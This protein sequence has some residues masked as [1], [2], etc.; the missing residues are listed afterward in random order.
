[1]IEN[2]HHSP[3]RSLTR[4]DLRRKQFLFKTRNTTIKNSNQSGR[5]DG[6]W[7]ALARVGVDGGD[8]RHNTL[9]GGW[10]WPKLLYM[11]EK[12]LKKHKK[13]RKKTGRR[14]GGD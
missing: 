1:M 7:L 4:A 9:E 2:L 14:G 11:A 12:H 6:H 5:H 10:K 13:E 8:G 3:R